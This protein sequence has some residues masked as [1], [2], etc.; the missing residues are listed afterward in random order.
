MTFQRYLELLA[1]LHLVGSWIQCAFRARLTG[2]LFF[3]QFA[4]QVGK[5]KPL[6]E[7]V[8]DSLCEGPRRIGE[9]SD[10]R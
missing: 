10:E 7:A 3:V 8:F 2:S 1:G 6:D 4:R 9:I 5:L